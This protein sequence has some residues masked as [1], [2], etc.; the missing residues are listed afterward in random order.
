MM[1]VA[2]VL[3]LLAAPPAAPAPSSETTPAP[4]PASVPPPAAGY[5]G[6]PIYPVPYPYP[7]TAETNAGPAAREPAE[8][9]YT[10]EVPARASWSLDLSFA[11]GVATGRF[12]NVLAGGAVDY[13]FGASTRLG[14]SLALANLKG[15]EGRV[16]DALVAATIS[17]EPPRPGSAFTFPLQF[18]TGYLIQNGPV[19]RLAAGLA[20][21][22]GQR[23]DLVLSVGAMAWVTRD[24][25]LLSL[26]LAAALRFRAAPW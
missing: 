1:H 25:M 2:T 16:N 6:Y 10:G 26:N 12:Q 3:V 17:Y 5:P 23:T 19:A 18:A 9:P 11:Q 7:V 4:V 8:P 22:L 24:D 13:R 15:K 14:G 20:W 21:A